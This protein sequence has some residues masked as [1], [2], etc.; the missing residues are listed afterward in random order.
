MSCK[1]NWLDQNNVLW[2]FIIIVII[3]YFFNDCD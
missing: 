3:S 1:N 2:I